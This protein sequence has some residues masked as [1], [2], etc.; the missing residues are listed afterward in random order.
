MTNMNKREPASD[1]ICTGHKMM[2][3][4]LTIA[5]KNQEENIYN[6]QK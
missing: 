6:L 5:V 1:P 4:S 2:D 3:Y